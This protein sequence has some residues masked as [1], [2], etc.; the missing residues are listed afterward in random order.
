MTDC[1]IDKKIAVMGYLCLDLFPDLKNGNTLEFVPGMLRE[2]GSCGVF[3]GGVIGNTGLALHKLGI[4]VKL[5]GKVGNDAF[6]Q[7]IQQ[8]LQQSIPES[9]LDLGVSDG[10]TAYCIVMS[11]PGCDR[12][13][14]AHR[15][16]ND[17]LTAA[18]AE[19]V[20]DED[21]A[22][23]HFGY[24][25]LC[26]E[27]AVDNGRELQKL[28]RHAGSKG[29]IT[30]LD[31]SLPSPGSSSY[32]MDWTAFMREVMPLTDIF[33]PSIDELEFMLKPKATGL[34]AK[35]QAMTEQ[36]LKLGA[37]IIAVKLGEDGL[38]VRTTNDLR[39]LDFLSAISA[40]N[41]SSWQNR[42]FIV[43]CRQVEVVGTTGAGDA[44][45]AG[46]LA[47]LM[48]GCSAETAGLLAVGTGACNVTSHD[49]V[50]GIKPLSAIRKMLADGWLKK[51][52]SFD[53]ET[54]KIIN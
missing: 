42:E 15:G 27:F 28:F 48:T 2:I 16:V 39:R 23:L 50:S 4:A 53:S 45:I 40:E 6:G 13:F 25:P 8:V 36:L 26:R 20:L 37:G 34:L 24:P 5:V 22:L 30:A 17:S 1:S 32:S 38:Y 3:A 7:V 52:L 33:L 54:I 46:F 49:S 14:L 12:M 19:N 29:I 31:M 11:P 43:P 18:D 51:E 9:A 10:E 41:Y 44:T 35:L 47:G 21:I